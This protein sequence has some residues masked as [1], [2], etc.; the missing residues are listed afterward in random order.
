MNWVMMVWTLGRRRRY[1]AKGGRFA[2]QWQNRLPGVQRLSNLDPQM[3][4]FTPKRTTHEYN[5]AGLTSIYQP[6]IANRATA[7]NSYQPKIAAR[8]PANRATG[9]LF[10]SH[11][12]DAF[13]PSKPHPH[14]VVLHSRPAPTPVREVPQK[15]SLGQQ[16]NMGRK[17]GQRE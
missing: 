8:A 4:T 13:E 3:Q 10:F 15:W 12:A 9:Q 1:A 6:K 11:R 17:D 2:D 14:R 16:R 7:K 5:P